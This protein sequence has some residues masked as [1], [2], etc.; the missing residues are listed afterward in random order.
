MVTD[1]ASLRRRSWSSISAPGFH[2]PSRNLRR[3]SIPFSA[4][5]HQTCGPHRCGHGEHSCHRVRAMII[6]AAECQEN[7]P[8]AFAD[9]DCTL[10]EN[11][12]SAAKAL[13]EGGRQ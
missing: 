5:S 11:L 1:R 4:V 3:V 12:A 2:K 9:R 7:E 10:V 8:E 13:I 6:Y